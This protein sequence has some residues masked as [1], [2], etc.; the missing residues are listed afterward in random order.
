[1]AEHLQ[2]IMVDVEYLA[3]GVD[4][5][6][7]NMVGDD[8]VQLAAELN[9]VRQ[10]CFA[11]AGQIA[12]RERA[13][14]QFPDARPETVTRDSH[15]WYIPDGPLDTTLVRAGASARLFQVASWAREPLG[16][17]EA[18]VHHDTRVLLDDVAQQLEEEARSIE[19]APRPPARSES[20]SLTAK[21]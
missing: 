18:A 14:G 16:I 2:A 5:A 6:C 1:M 13:L 12:A 9:R 15:G 10:R 17:S 20:T 3:F 19:S 7:W 21:E 11:I 4:H 8:A